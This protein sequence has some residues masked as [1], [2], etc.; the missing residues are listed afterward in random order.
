M[1]FPG[2]CAPKFAS[3]KGDST[4][5]KLSWN[6]IELPTNVNSMDLHLLENLVTSKNDGITDGMVCDSSV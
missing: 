1:R 2:G 3:V 5:Y 4:L 6:D